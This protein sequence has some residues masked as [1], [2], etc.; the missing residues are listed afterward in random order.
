MQDTYFVIPKPEKYQESY[1]KVQEI[2]DELL[3][4]NYEI[5][6]DLIEAKSAAIVASIILDEVREGINL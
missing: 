1:E 3:K 6:S 5:C 4:D 2:L